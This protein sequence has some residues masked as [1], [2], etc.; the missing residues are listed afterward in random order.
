LKER[1]KQKYLKSII[2]TK[3]SS[4]IRLCEYCFIFLGDRKVDIKTKHFLPFNN[5]L[6]LKCT[7]AFYSG[8]S[9]WPQM[10]LWVKGENRILVASQKQKWRQV[11]R[12]K[13]QPSHV[14]QGWKR[15]LLG[16][17][18]GHNNERCLLGVFTDNLCNSKMKVG[19][20]LMKF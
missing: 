11:L 10:V 6:H 1:L 2:V 13:V 19:L 16:K 9:D 8:R 18:Q 4:K 7:N 14:E 12:N 15:S 3:G 17:R 20:L 5:E